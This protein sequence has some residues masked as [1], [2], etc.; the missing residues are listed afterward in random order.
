MAC[1][2]VPCRLAHQVK[3]KACNSGRMASSTARDSGSSAWRSTTAMGAARRRRRMQFK[4]ASSSESAYSKGI[5]PSSASQ[6]AACESQFIILNS[7][8]DGV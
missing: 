1:G 4:V 5:A 3:P 6:G 2:C 8:V 7:L